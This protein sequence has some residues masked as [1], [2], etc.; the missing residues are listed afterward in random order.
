MTFPILNSSLERLQLLI[1]GVDGQ[2]DQWT[3]DEV[4]SIMKEYQF[5]SKL[6]RLEY[7]GDPADRARP[8]L[9]E[10][11]RHFG[12]AFV[13]FGFVLAQ[14]SDD[15]QNDFVDAGDFF[16]ESICKEVFKSRMINKLRW[17]DFHSIPKEAV[18]EYVSKVD[19][20]AEDI[21]PVFENFFLNEAKKMLDLAQKHVDNDP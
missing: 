5:G 6:K 21:Y 11:I 17:V 3:C 2:K 8:D 4:K 9:P 15:P 18:Q 10:H 7:V 1:L 16:G 13:F 20:L 14:N 19:S 12:T